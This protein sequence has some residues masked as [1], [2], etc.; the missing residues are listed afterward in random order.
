MMKVIKIVKTIGPEGNWE[1]VRA[2]VK[3]KQKSRKFLNNPK[4]WR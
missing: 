3:R 1:R 2:Y 4:N